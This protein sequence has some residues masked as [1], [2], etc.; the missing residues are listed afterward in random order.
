MRYFDDDA[1]AFLRDLKRHNDR[2]WFNEHKERY[3]R[4]LRQPF[5]DFISDVGPELRTISPNLVADPRPSGGSLFRI[6]RDVRFSKDKSP[7]KTHAGAHFQLG[8]KGVHGPGYYLHLEPGECFVAG[9]MWMPEPEVLQAIRRRIADDPSA[10]AKARG[11]LDHSEETLKRPPRGFD[12]DH[13]MIEDIK[14]KSFTGSVRLTDT[15]VTST[16]FM[17]T[18]VRDCERVSPLMA[19][20]ASAAGVP[21]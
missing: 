17:A 2:A 1:L 20:L 16:T 21:W 12:A 10:W 15:Q 9:G 4:S 14:R 11:K 13:P 8:G 3:E 5:L 18:F 7:Y 19:F 6:H